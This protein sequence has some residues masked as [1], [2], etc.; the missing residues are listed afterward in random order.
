MDCH[1]GE[2]FSARSAWE[3]IIAGRRVGKG[4]MT[5]RDGK[6]IFALHGAL[7]FAEKKKKGGKEMN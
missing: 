7:T 3:T 2:P 1:S 4:N 5:I 6:L